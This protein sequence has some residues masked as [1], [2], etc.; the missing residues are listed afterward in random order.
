MPLV[1]HTRV[2]DDIDNCRITTNKIAGFSERVLINYPSTESENGGL[3][4]YRSTG[5]EVNVVD[6]S[7]IYNFNRIL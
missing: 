2:I 1:S 4:G 3:D 5:Q 7:V 6:E